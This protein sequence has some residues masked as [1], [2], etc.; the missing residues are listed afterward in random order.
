MTT[1]DVNVSSKLFKLELSV[2][3]ALCES[4]NSPRSL[5]IHLLVKYEEWAQLLNL[6]CNPDHYDDVERFRMDY[7]CTVA[8]SKNPRVPT[9]VDRRAIALAK[10]EEAE[11]SCRQAN[12][13]IAS[14]FHTAAPDVVRA[15]HSAHGIIS[16]ILGPLTRTRLEEVDEHMRFGP[17]STTSVSGVVTLGRK[18]SSRIVDA[19]PRVASFGLHCLPAR[20]RSE[21][22]GFN[23]I[24]SS[25]LTTVPKSAKTDRVIC[26]E[27]DLNIYVQLGVGAAIRSRLQR[28][29]L[30]LNHGQEVNRFMA[31]KAVEWD[32]TTMDLSSASDLICREAV[33][34]L[35]PH[36]WADLLHFCRVDTTTDS[37]TGKA[38]QLEKWSSMGNGYT[39]ELETLIFWGV[40]R[41]ALRSLGISES[42]AVA[43]GDDLIFP[44]QALS[45][46]TRT[47]EFLG[48][49]VNKEKTF[50]KGLFRESCGTDWYNGIDVR[51]LF[52]KVDTHDFVSACYIYGN[53]ITRVASRSRSGLARDSRFLPA[54]L[55][56][57]T[58]AAPSDRHRVPCGSGDEGFHSSFEESVPT[59]TRPK[60]GWEGFR[61]RVR[62]IG[63]IETSTY[64]SGCYISALH[65]GKM[66]QRP[67]Y[68]REAMRGRFSSPELGWGLV[69]TWP[70]LGAWV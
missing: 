47:L 30:D 12:E 7:Q 45:L 20:W 54:W 38:Y 35:L 60:H 43:Y 17:G 51:P 32:L 19:T 65:R 63:T 36:D 8:L 50:S 33:W 56:C 3:R 6:E 14:H 10:F 53:A 11:V 55:R 23:L 34:L 42:L 26:V 1:H 13:R 49:R 46:V 22:I 25:K 21:V 16:G 62:R 67:T 9:G 18:F 66:S 40:V 48:F 37:V 39:F 57:F 5:M 58:A 52:L 24:T 29:G 68:G 41:G 59:I 4:T 27:P 70:Y 2:L 31:S 61:F 44:S 64:E 15:L 69:S 28:S